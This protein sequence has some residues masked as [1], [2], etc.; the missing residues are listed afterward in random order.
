MSV[1]LL[2]SSREP[3]ALVTRFK[4]SE[5][6][7]IGKEHA[8][9]QAFLISIGRGR[10][11]HGGRWD[12]PTSRANARRRAAGKLPDLQ[13][14]GQAGLRPA[15]LVLEGARRAGP[16]GLPDQRRVPGGLGGGWQPVHRAVLR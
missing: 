11:G 15:S 5:A 2:L 13:G 12:R 3:S 8:Y 14:D 16:A 7:I 10:Y 9:A 1:L 4:S 6:R